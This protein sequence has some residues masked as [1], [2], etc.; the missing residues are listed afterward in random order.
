MVRSQEQKQKKKA[1]FDREYDFKNLELESK[2]K[3]TTDS[4]ASI[5]LLKKSLLK[6][7]NRHDVNSSINIFLSLFERQISQ[8][9]FRKVEKIIHSPP[10][11]ILNIIT[12]KPHPIAEE[13]D[14]V[15]YYC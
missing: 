9:N 5:T 8:I 12:R 14:H 2:L 1:A 6:L 10:L 13:H 4:Y 11:E 3:L 7:V 15:R